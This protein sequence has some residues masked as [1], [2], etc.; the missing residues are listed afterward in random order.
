MSYASEYS[1][2]AGAFNTGW[3]KVKSAGPPVV[4]EARTP[5]AWPNVPYEPTAG[6]PWVA[7]N[8]V[9]GEAQQ[10]SAG[11]PGNNI[12]R[13]VGMV[14][15]QIFVPLH[16]G[17]SAARALGDN[18]ITLFSGLTLAGYRFRPAYVSA[19][20]TNSGQKGYSLVDGWRQINVTVPF[21]RDE[22][23]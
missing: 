13:H 23:M 22:F 20:T 16:Q 12:V 10:V 2:L 11:A 8:V 6:V 21:T 18:V 14:V 7:F 19:V 4:Y 5:V 9:N 1:A 17:E 15:I 3:V